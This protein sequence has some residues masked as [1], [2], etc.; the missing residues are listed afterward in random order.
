M[1]EKKRVLIVE[2]QRYQYEVICKE[3]KDYDVYPE[4][5]ENMA[6]YSKFI[7]NV[8]VWVNEQYPIRDKAEKYI[9]EYVLDFKIDIIIMDHIIGGAHHCLTGVDLAIMINK[10]MAK[11]DKIVKVLFLSNVEY[12]NKER[13]S[14]YCDYQKLFPESS[15]WVLKGYFGDEILNKEYFEKNIIKVISELL[16]DSK[17]INRNGIDMSYISHKYDV[18]ISHASED[19]KEFVEPLANYLQNEGLRVWY[20]DFALKLGDK[21]RQT[22]DNGLTCSQYGIVVLSKAFFEKD[23]TKY[24]LDTLAT[25]EFGGRK[26][27]LPIWHGV[28]KDEISNFSISLADR[29]AIRSDLPLKNI[30]EKIIEIVRE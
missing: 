23:W 24:E 12:G 15:E 25:R 19:K 4:N 29:V 10:Y 6:A 27:I 3:L 13:L 30:A 20:D 17:K 2:N 26:V 7:D 18:F 5:I 28:T 11:N 1:S 16:G 9:I 22:I 8:A 14:K 21:L